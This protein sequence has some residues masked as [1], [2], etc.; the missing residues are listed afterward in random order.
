MRGRD[1][2]RVEKVNGGQHKRT[3]TVSAPFLIACQNIKERDM[4]MAIGDDDDAAFFAWEPKRRAIFP[5]IPLRVLW[6]VRVT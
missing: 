4:L 5:L 6:T 3:P 2:E 1:Y